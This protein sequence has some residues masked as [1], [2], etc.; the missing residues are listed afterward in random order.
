MQGSNHPDP[1]TLSTI[2]APPFS[3]SP[4]PVT[5]DGR[6]SS[7]SSSSSASSY[8]FDD[9]WRLPPPPQAA[10]HSHP[11][12][13]TIFR[14]RTNSLSIQPQNSFRTIL[15]PSDRIPDP[16]GWTHPFAS[17]RTPTREMPWP[18]YPNSWNTL[19]GERNRPGTA[20]DSLNNGSYVRRSTGEPSSEAPSPSL[21]GPVPSSTGRRKRAIVPIARPEIPSSHHVQRY[22]GHQHQHHRHDNSTDNSSSSS[23]ISRESSPGVP[24]FS[25]ADSASSSSLYQVEQPLA[26]WLRP[27]SA[28]QLSRG[29]PVLFGVIRS[30]GYHFQQPQPRFDVGGEPEWF[31]LP[32]VSSSLPQRYSMTTSTW[33]PVGG[34]FDGEVEGQLRA[35]RGSDPLSSR[36]PLPADDEGA[37]TGRYACVHCRKCLF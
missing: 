35:R 1:S 24:T 18:L 27:A 36:T 19:P 3:H 29:P 26:S 23:S 37:E 30:E 25:A 13:S 31:P 32:P 33:P 22:Q 2:L 11:P 16:V 7:S 15:T 12:P 17:D 10:R 34:G 5:C 14:R 4:S 8:N 21:A 20:P 9:E 28:G 6:P